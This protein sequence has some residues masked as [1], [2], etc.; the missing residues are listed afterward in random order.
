VKTT[1]AQEVPKLWAEILQ[2]VAAGEEVQVTADGKPVALLTP[3]G[4]TGSFI[5][6]TAGGP[7]LPLDL[8]EPTGEKW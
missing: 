6:A 7:A 3:C 1:K 5:G 8:D 2:W 4:G